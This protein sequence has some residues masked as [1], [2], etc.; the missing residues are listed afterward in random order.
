MLELYHWEPNTF[1][2]KPLI[3]LK[4]KQAA[5]TSRYFDPTRFEQFAP[6]ISA[7]RGVGPAPGARRPGAGAR[8][9][10]HQ[11]LIFHAGVHRGRIARC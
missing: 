10:D 4:E 5:F 7:Q 6:G 1:F 8:R 3:A 11:Q 9:H 2:L